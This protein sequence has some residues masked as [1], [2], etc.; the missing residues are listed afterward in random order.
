MPG[1]P[2]WKTCGSECRRGGASGG[3][4]IRGGGTSGGGA[5]GG[6]APVGA[7][8]DGAVL[9]AAGPVLTVLVKSRGA[10]LSRSLDVLNGTHL[11]MYLFY[12]LSL[13]RTVTS[14]G[15]D[16]KFSLTLDYSQ[17]RLKSSD[18]IIVLTLAESLKPVQ[19][20]LRLDMAKSGLSDSDKYLPLSFGA[21]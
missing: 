4:S 11:L 10:V 16:Q 7:R 3:G 2:R 9:G 18:L 6:G 5:R 13:S 14:F 21:K 15:L 8:G 17:L 1:C 20:N 12:S 19:Q